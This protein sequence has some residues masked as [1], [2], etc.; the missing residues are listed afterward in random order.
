MG[1]FRAKFSIEYQKVEK[2]E[3]K[4]LVPK[5]N[6]QVFVEFFSKKGKTSK[7][8]RKQEKSS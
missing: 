6:N 4:R 8:K 3:W 1:S 2:L 5:E 7:E